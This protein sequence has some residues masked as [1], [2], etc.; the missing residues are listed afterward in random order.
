MGVFCNNKICPYDDCDLKWKHQ[1]EFDEDGDEPTVVDL[2]SSCQRVT[3]Y[4]ADQIN[5]LRF[6]KQGN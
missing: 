4:L 1:I 3:R 5:N 6:E 2:Q